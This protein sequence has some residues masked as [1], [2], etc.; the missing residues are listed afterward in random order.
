MKTRY[1]VL[2]SFLIGICCILIGMN[3][4]GMDEIGDFSFIQK[5]VQRIGD[6]FYEFENVHSL[7]LDLANAHVNIHEE[8]NGHGIKVVATHLYEGFEIEQDGDTIEINQKFH[9]F[10]KYNQDSSQIDIYVPQGYIFQEVNVD[11]HGKNTISHVQAEYF[12]L[13]AGFGVVDVYGLKCYKEVNVDNAFGSTSIEWL[14]SKNDIDYSTTAVFGTV[15]ID[16]EKYGA[17]VA[18]D[19]FMHDNEKMLDVHS[20]AGTVNIRTEDSVYE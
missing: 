14:T 2:M 12:D 11:A 9:I 10:K 8:H 20:F 4:N 18:R 3:L 17:F 6:Q 19:K 7:E 1:K 15:Q 13:D 5:D 16:Y